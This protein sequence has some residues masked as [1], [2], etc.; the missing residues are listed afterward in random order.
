M[1]FTCKKKC[2]ILKTSL[3][4][5]GKKIIGSS[6]RKAGIF[7]YDPNK[8]KVLIVQSRGNL[9]GLPKGTMKM[10]ESDKQCAIRE[11]KEETGLMIKEDEFIK[12][13]II[14]NRATYFYI[15]REMCDIKIQ[16]HIKNNDA[17]ALGW[18]TPECLEQ[19]IIDGCITLNQ[20]CRIV[21][22]RF[23]GII[24]SHS[25]FHSCSG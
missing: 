7:I 12:S 14:R 19:C 9:W 6:H 11:V 25:T 2:C 3:Y 13:T 15:E 10:G 5:T 16:D 1:N 23:L 20:H 21:F 8:N 17:N 22:R 4:I 24:F 18:I